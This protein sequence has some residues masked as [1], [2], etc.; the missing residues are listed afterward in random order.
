MQ[1]N[2]RPNLHL[3]RKLLKFL[4]AQIEFCK[5]ITDGEEKTCGGC[6]D[7]DAVY[8]KSTSSGGH[9]FIVKREH[10]LTSG[11]IKAMWGGPGQFAK[12]ETKEVN[13]RR[14]PHMCMCFTYKVPILTAPLSSTDILEFPTALELLIAAN[15]LDC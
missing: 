8:V 14:V 12:D 6:E 15:F 11:T 2:S 7:P 4:W 10:A 1:V 9:E 5:N 3:A 13:F